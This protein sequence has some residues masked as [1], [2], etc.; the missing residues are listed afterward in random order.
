MLTT[1]LD[2]NLTELITPVL[3]D[4]LEEKNGCTLEAV[5]TVDRHA[6][7]ATIASLIARA[8]SGAPLIRYALVVN[9]LPG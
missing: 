5:G 3:E 9:L 2:S 7:R 4:L 1:L 6:R 8:R